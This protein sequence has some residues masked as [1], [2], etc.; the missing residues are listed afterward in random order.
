MVTALLHFGVLY[1]VGDIDR[2]G[3]VAKIERY[4]RDEMSR[5][6]IPGLSVAVVRGGKIDV[7]RGFGLA[8][9]ELAAPA[10]EG[11]VYEIQSLTKQF[12]AAAI[13]LLVEDA[14]VRLDAPIS[15]YLPHL[16]E[17]WKPITVRQLLSHTAGIPDYTEAPGWS[18]SSRLDRTPDDLLAPIR[19]RPLE[20]VPGSRWKYSNSNYYVL[21]EIIEKAGG[22]SWAGFLRARIFRPLGMSN[23]CANDLSDILAGRASGYHWSGSKIVNVPPVSPSQKWAAGG[24]V[25]TATDL[26]VW[27]LALRSGKLLG[28]GSLSQ[29]L[30]PAKLTPG[31]VAPYGFGNELE[32]DHGHPVA[33]HQGSGLAY[34]CSLLRYVK[35]D[36][37]VIVLANLTQGHTHA[38]A[39][40]IATFYLPG[41][42]DGVG[43]P[44]DDP[45]LSH[46]LELIIN[47][48]AKGR[49]DAAQFTEGAGRE[50]LPFIQRAGPR[51][52]GTLGDLTSFTLIE[53]KGN[54]AQRIRRYR[55]IY[56]T[57]TV[58]WSFTL[59]RDGKVS[60]ME[61]TEE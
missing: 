25:S 58:V 19:R 52:L 40:K 49:V 11:T 27:E 41:L 12:T 5:G 38:I 13:M 14:K 9:V 30:S 35:D 18:A 48:A 51:M 3:P 7:A 60:A 36:V 37:T 50:M 57:K 17:A 23:T 46:R 31:G 55:A 34:N 10:S 4:V 8:N 56:A 26:A 44:D 15:A 53:R 1:V 20:F 24:V 45:S 29:M 61:P 16:P 21:G 2:S 32:T 39:R 33:G 54:G 59:E 47:E 42:S 22:R 28:P 6:H 43:V